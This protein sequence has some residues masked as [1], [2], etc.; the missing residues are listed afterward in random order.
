VDDTVDD[1]APADLDERFQAH[2]DGVPGAEG[3]KSAYV[4]RSF[5]AGSL[6]V[7]F[8]EA[9]LV[10]AAVKYGRAIAHSVE[11]AASIKERVPVSELELSVDE[12]DSPTSVVEHLFIAREIRNRGIHLDSLA[13]RFVGDFEK[14]V[15]YKGDVAEFEARLRD[16][17]RSPGTSVRTRSACTPATTIRRHPIVARVTGHLFHL[18]PAPA[19]SKPPRS[20]RHGVPCCGRSSASAAA[21]DTDKATYH[22]SARIDRVRRRRAS[23]TATW[24][25]ITSTKTTAARSASPGRAPP[26][27]AAGH[28]PRSAP[29]AAQSRSQYLRRG[30]EKHIGRH[31]RGLMAP[32]AMPTAAAAQRAGDAGSR[33]VAQR[34]SP[35]AERFVAGRDRP[36][37]SEGAI[38]GWQ[39]L[40][41]MTAPHSTKL[42]I[43]KVLTSIR[44][45][46]GVVAID[47]G[48]VCIL[49]HL[50]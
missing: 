40:I 26:A 32:A 35:R 24:R 48:K 46:A 1:A 33:S 39:Q 42:M 28:L 13:P 49:P 30:P 29:L 47:G 18:R 31:I 22:I 5:T 7:T 50:Q 25:A 4:G 3:W 23:R 38:A 43:I 15:D 44:P 34:T 41:I 19:T 37:Q 11:M 9:S 17:S 12:T 21:A 45:A 20:R 2:R 6:T 36:G 16:T 10:K 14:G 8:D 27:K